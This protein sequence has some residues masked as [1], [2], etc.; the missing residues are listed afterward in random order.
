MFRDATEQF[1]LY[2]LYTVYGAIDE[3]FFRNWNGIQPHAIRMRSNRIGEKLYEISS[4]SRYQFWKNYKIYLTCF[5]YIAYQNG[6]D[7]YW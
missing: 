6:Y 5:I 1:Y 7:G 4:R 3:Q 2:L